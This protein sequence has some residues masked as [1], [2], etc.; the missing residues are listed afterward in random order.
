VLSV[1]ALGNIGLRHG[2]EIHGSAT[3]AHGAH[4]GETLT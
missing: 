2:L 1:P 4:L 3:R